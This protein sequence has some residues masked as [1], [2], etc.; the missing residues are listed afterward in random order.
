MK[1]NTKI[2]LLIIILFILIISIGVYKKS[3]INKIYDESYFGKSLH[4]YTNTL[5]ATS[6]NIST[7]DT[8]IEYVN[9]EYGF[10]FSLPLSWKGYS[11]INS[12]WE[13]NL[14]DASTNNKNI[15]GPKILIRH[16]LWTSKNPRQDIPIMIFTPNQWDLVQQE[17]ISLGAAPIPPSELEGNNKYIFAIPARYNFAFPEGF[18]EVIKIIESKPLNI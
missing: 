6:S 3:I 10:T 1:K 7:N 11:I 15:L 4:S 2:K 16:P 12:N 9:T 5:T 14:I 8:K 13:G 18:E 17:K